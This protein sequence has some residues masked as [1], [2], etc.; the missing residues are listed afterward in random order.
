MVDR[1][2]SVSRDRSHLHSQR[3]GTSA[4]QPGSAPLFDH[5]VDC[6]RPFSRV[7]GPDLA[8]GAQLMAHVV[9][10]RQGGV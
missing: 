2:P 1:R 10:R 5:I 4:A 3:T 7:V 6:P 9:G 8:T